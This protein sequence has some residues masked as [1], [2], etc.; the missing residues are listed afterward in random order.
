MP[1]PSKGRCRIHRCSENRHNSQNQT[2][3]PEAKLT[4]TDVVQLIVG[5][6]ELTSPTNPVWASVRQHR[7]PILYTKAPLPIGVSPVDVTFQGLE[8]A[9]SVVLE[10]ASTGTDGVNIICGQS[11][12]CGYH[13]IVAVII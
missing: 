9:I 11:V 8:P 2:C 6:T 7:R 12:V 3:S 4:K 13:I 1:G 10:T 5:G